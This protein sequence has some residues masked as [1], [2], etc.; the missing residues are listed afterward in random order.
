MPVYIGDDK[1]NE[2]HCAVGYDIFIFLYK[3]NMV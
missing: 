3:M 1:K 2:A